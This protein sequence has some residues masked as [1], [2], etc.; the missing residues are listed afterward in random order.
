MWNF[1]LGGAGSKLFSFLA[2]DQFIQRKLFALNFLIVITLW[3]Q[4]WLVFFSHFDLANRKLD[5]RTD[6]IRNLRCAKF[7]CWC[8]NLLV[9]AKNSL[10]WTK[11]DRCTNH[12]LKH[13][14]FHVTRSFETKRWLRSFSSLSP[15]SKKL[16]LYLMINLLSLDVAY[17]CS[18][19]S[20]T[21][22]CF[23]KTLT[24]RNA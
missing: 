20:S 17:F 19:T 4:K 22:N 24:A 14:I 13:I 21:I 10:S 9:R 1:L 7:D 12:N 16:F 6:T 8:K 15:W 5:N 18:W 2:Q 23:S 3:Y 11:K